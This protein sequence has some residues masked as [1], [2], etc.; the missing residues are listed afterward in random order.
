MAQSTEEAKTESKLGCA[1]IVGIGPGMGRSLALRFAAGGYNIALISRS[2]E[3]TEAVAKEINEKYKSIN[4][5]CLS[6]DTTSSDACNAAYKQIIDEKN[7]L[8]RVELL[9]FNAS[10]RPQFPPPSFLEVKLD[11]L[12]KHFNVGVKGITLNHSNKTHN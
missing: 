10:A 3:K 8:G 1:V 12:E 4:T 7:K 11:E 2:K 5:L 6:V 9:C